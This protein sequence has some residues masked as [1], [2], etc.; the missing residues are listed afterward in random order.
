[1]PPL[2]PLIDR[3]PAGGTLTLSPAGGEFEGPATISRPIQIAGCGGTI[4]AKSGPVLTITSGKVRIAECNVEVTGKSAAADEE[5][6]I[7][8][9]GTAAPQFD[10]VTVHG[11]VQGIASEAGRWGYTRS[12]K[13]GRIAARTD[14]KFLFLIQIP[15]ACRFEI[16]VDGAKVSP[17]SA[18]AGDVLLT[19]S[20]EACPL[21][22]RVRGSLYLISKQLRRR[23]A[24]TGSCVEPANAATANG[25]MLWQ[26]PNVAV[27]IPAEPSAKPQPPATT[28]RPVS[29]QPPRAKPP[30]G[31]K[32]GAAPPVPVPPVT[33]KRQPNSPAPTKPTRLP[34]RPVGTPTA[35]TGG[36]AASS[37]PRQGQVPPETE[38][39]E[40]PP[41]WE[42][43]P[44]SIP[45]GGIWVD[46]PAP[47]LPPVVIPTEVVAPTP[48]V[49]QPAK[50]VEQPRM[51]PKPVASVPVGGAFGDA[52]APPPTPTGSA[53]A[54]P[55][56]P[57][58]A[59]PVVNVP[60]V[61]S[62]P[63]QLKPKQQPKFSTPAS[64]IPLGGAFE[65]EPN[66]PASQP[67]PAAAVPEPPL[68]VKPKASK[69]VQPTGD[70]GAFE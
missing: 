51:A 26:P 54:P 49:G 65:A 17:Q 45:I 27:S 1:M 18:P 7:D 34:K 58:E 37:S 63:P 38:L 10:Q 29:T 11:N 43:S 21:H 64:S 4:W 20:L 14:L 35:Q 3:T 50:A 15:V 19:I 13:A 9:K 24:L 41:E 48:V 67:E 46:A 6:A 66:S 28:K 42:A 61:V 2:Q 33:D 5:L 25:S 62:V 69:K 12:L 36:G 70:F 47:V 55:P 68:E 8:V 60:P 31:A 30:V 59:S 57:Q 32:P 40:L 53:V 52:P 44:S 16:D 22:T 39:L 56:P 23:V